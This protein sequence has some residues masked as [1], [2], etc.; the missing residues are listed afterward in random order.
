MFNTRRINLAVHVC[1]RKQTT[2]RWSDGEKAS[3]FFRGAKCREWPLTAAPGTA[4]RG[5]YWVKTGH[6][7][8]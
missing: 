3:L 8:Q 1:P 7:S 4:R 2:S 5:R 6:G